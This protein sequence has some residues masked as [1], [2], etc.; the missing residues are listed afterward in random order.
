MKQINNV[1]AAILMTGL[2]FSLGYKPITKLSEDKS[3]NN[4]T[5]QIDNIY[6]SVKIGNQ[7][8][9]VDNLNVD[10]YRNGDKIPEVQ[11]EEQWENLKTGAWCYYDSNQENNKK[12]GKLYNWYA[13]HDPRGLAPNGWHIPDTSEFITLKQ[14]VNN[15]GSALQ[16]MGQESEGGVGTNTSGF[17]VLLAGYRSSNGYFYYLGYDAYFWSITEYD[18]YGAYYLF[19][20]GTGSNIALSVD[21]KEGGFSVR[22]IKD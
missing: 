15:D 8:W 11:D 2:I 5:R 6:R 14:S 13:V 12:Y 9:M 21:S 20:Y 1:I 7:E 17:S 3:S 16:A 22:C 19:L 4:L 10:H 18:T